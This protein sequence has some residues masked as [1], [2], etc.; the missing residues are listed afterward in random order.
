MFFYIPGDGFD[1]RPEWILPADVLQKKQLIFL[2]LQHHP[3]WCL[4][5][6]SAGFLVVVG[7]IGFWLGF[8]DSTFLQ[9]L[10]RFCVWLLSVLYVHQCL[11]CP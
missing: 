11:D 9:G 4:A 6:T 5:L 3:A 7:C 10:V 2:T 8:R 1:C